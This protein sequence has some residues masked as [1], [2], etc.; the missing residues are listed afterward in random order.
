MGIIKKKMTQISS[1]EE[2]KKIT[3]EFNKKLP[4]REGYK[5]Y[6]NQVECAIEGIKFFDC[7]LPRSNHLVI[8]GKTQAGK[9]GVFAAMMM[10]IDKYQIENAMSITDIYYITGDNS[11]KLIK[12]TEERLAHCFNQSNINC[13]FHCLKNSNLNNE[14]NNNNEKLTNAL[15]FIDESHYGINYDN[16]VLIKW[17]KSK[18]LNMHNDKELSEKNVYI[19]SNS[20]TPYN[21]INSDI[22]NCKG[23]VYLNVDEWNGKNGYVG[24]QQFYQENCFENIKS[25]TEKN[26]DEICSKFYNRLKEIHQKTGKY[27]V[28]IIRLTYDSYKKVENII[29]KYF[30]VEVFSSRT[31]KNIN[32]AE[33]EKCIEHCNEFD[34]SNEF[35]EKPLAIIIHGAYRM[36]ISIPSYCKLN[37]GI[38]CDYNKQSVI[39]TEQGL[40]GRI[41]GYWD[42][43]N[44]KDISIYINEKHYNALKTCYVKHA[45]STPL[46][47]DK[48]IFIPDEDGNEIGIV[49]QNNITKILCNS[50]TFDGKEYNNDVDKFVREYFKNIGKPLPT[51]IIFF[52][53]RRNIKNSKKYIKQ[54]SFNPNEE[55]AKYLLKDMKNI[56]HPCYT[57]LYDNEENAIFL[58]YG[59]IKK[60]R[61]ETDYIEDKKIISTLL[62]EIS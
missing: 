58:I 25:I 4:N 54:P 57:T 46:I 29:K 43:D 7:D 62:T 35:Y 10:L 48:K 45:T 52:P 22:I 8:I 40:L 3:D 56:D 59:I 37:I 13:K 49:K 6:H 51:D 60:G 17:L 16:N 24:F 44:W 53:G 39:T 41:S 5:L 61:Y 21:E 2:I 31:D 33:I 36:G 34:K 12:Q 42:N 11:R 20:A 30:C 26:C 38:I 32:Y 23:Y 9:T 19:I 47:K 50:I 55:K 27:K 18:N 14:L 15:I 1:K 28:A